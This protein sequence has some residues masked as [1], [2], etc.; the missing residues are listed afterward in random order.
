MARCGILAALIPLVQRVQEL[1]QA[2]KRVALQDGAGLSIES[3]QTQEI[4]LPRLHL[5][6]NDT[7]QLTIPNGD[8]PE[9]VWE[10]NCILQLRNAEQLQ[11]DFIVTNPPYIIRKTGTFS[12]PDP[13][14]YDWSI[15]GSRMM[16][17]YGY[18]IW[19]AAQRVKPYTGVSCMITASQWLTLE[20]AAKLR[21]WL[22]ESC[23]MDEFFQFEPFKVFSKVQ[24]DSL[25][26]KIRALGPSHSDP[27]RRGRVLQEHCTAFLR[28]TD[29]HRP[30]AG[31]LQDYMDFNLESHLGSSIATTTASTR[32]YSFAPMMPSSGL[33]AYLLALTQD[34]GGICSAGTKKINRLS[35]PEPL[36]WH[37]GPNTNPVYGLVARME[38]ARVNFGSA[39][40]DR[41]FRPAMY[42]NGKNSPEESALGA[43]SKVI[44]K[45][46]LFWQ[47]RDRLR[48]SK[49][50]GSPA[51]SYI[52]PK[53]DPRRLYALCMVDRESV[54][55]LKQQVEQGVEGSLALWSYLKDKVTPTGKQQ[56]ADDEGVAYCSTNQCGSDVPEKIIHPINYGYFSKTQPRQRFF[57]DNNSL[58]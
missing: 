26:F 23:L 31:I 20:F 55:V 17:V 1:S 40:V 6:R 49:K 25:V 35:A 12:A 14:V 24:T 8:D 2:N 36:L 3:R 47:S 58:A 22:F 5:F 46:G 30:L 41:W 7:L 18:F 57:L 48:L 37:R 21:A 16:Q 13:E 52:V 15:L 56:N 53:P 39:M 33:T 54:K 38:Y 19:F 45:E 27:S 34:L 44:H 11:F 28:H 10:R 51:E 32:T 4:K 43:S 9:T 50:E 42:W 29:H